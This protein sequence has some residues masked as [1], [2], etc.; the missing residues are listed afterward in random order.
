MQGPFYYCMG[1]FEVYFTPKEPDG[2]IPEILCQKI[3]ELS[4]GPS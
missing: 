2:R 4:N 3:S 1:R